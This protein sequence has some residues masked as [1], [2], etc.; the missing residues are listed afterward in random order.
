MPKSNPPP[1]VSEALVVWL[2]GIF[3]D[4]LPKGDFKLED[5]QQAIGS[6]RVIDKLR[7]ACDNPTIL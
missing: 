1:P 4:R 3:P 6:R 7:Q 5:I 2:D